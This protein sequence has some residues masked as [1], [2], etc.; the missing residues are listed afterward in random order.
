LWGKGGAPRAVESDAVA[1][2]AAERFLNA[3]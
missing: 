3:T 2:A 1:M